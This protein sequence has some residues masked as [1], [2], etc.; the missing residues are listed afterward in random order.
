GPGHRHRSAAG[1]DRGEGDLDAVSEAARAATGPL[2]R[3]RSSATRCDL[4]AVAHVDAVVARIRA[5]DAA[6]AGHLHVGARRGDLPRRVEEDAVVGA[7]AGRTR[8]AGTGYGSR[9][10]RAAL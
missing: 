4:G 1:R 2:D 5:A 8:P 9:P 3:D 10:A 6:D 7:G